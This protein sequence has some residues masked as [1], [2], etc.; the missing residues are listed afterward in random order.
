MTLPDFLSREPDG[1]IFVAG[2]RVTVLHIT[3]LYAEGYTPEQLADHF[4]T[5]PLALM[6]KVIAFYLENRS[7]VDAYRTRCRQEIDRQAT[8]PRRGPDRTE[9]QRRMEA[10][11]RSESA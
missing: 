7:E 1:T 9:L 2:H 8:L 10:L 6:H 5:L 3:D 11:R 4:P